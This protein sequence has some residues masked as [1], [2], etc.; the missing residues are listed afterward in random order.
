M[1]LRNLNRDKNMSKA[2]VRGKSPKN[3][4]T[5][6]V[7]IVGAGFAGMYM[8]HKIQQRGLSVRLYEAG[9]G[10]GGTWYWNRYPGARVD[11]ESVEYSYSFDD[12]LQQDWS[13]S[14][15]YA[16]QPELMR[17]ANY[18]ADRFSLRENMRCDTKV[19]AAVYDAEKLNWHIT[20]SQGDEVSAKYCVLATG[21]LSSGSVPDF[22]GLNDYNGNT[23]LTSKWPKEDINFK[24]Q[25]VAVIGT[26]SSA[27]QSIPIIAMQADHLT[28]F[29][30]TPSFSIPA[31]NGPMDREYE[32]RVKS[33]YPEW[34]RRQR[35]ESRAGFIA[36]NFQ[37]TAPNNKSAID[38]SDEERLIDYE[39]RW[40]SG[41]L[42][43]YNSFVDLLTNEKANDTL[44]KFVRNKIREK[45]KD[46]DTAELLAPKDY[47]IM[48]KR[49]CADTNYYETYNRENVS[50]VSIKDS[51][52]EKLT[53]KGVVVGG[54]EYEVDSVIFATGF[55]AVTG[56]IKNIDV[57]GV[58]GESL[59]E[60]WEG[61][62]RAYLGLM[63]NGFPNLFFL[64]GPCANGA[65]VSPML[66]SEHQ[67]E[68]VDRCI[69]EI[70]VGLAA[71][72]EPTLEA[73]DA[74]MQHMHDVGKDSLL[75][76][77]NSW[78]MGAN[79][80]GK[81]RALLSYL[82]GLESYRQQCRSGEANDYGNFVKT[83]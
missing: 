25:K 8:Q 19:T 82:G 21:F 28:V 23:Y 13:W 35:Y 11:V 42:C 3:Q 81:P 26:G 14:E 5:F 37:P 29:Q 54:H 51:P 2:G 64:D 69:N 61:A 80:P 15:R 41:G 77:A 17:Y 38:V 71:E 44:A 62:P 24:D 7:V 55:D 4:E 74:W 75:H 27:V 83:R 50:L 12:D 34:R 79:I 46:P 1:L 16:S 32:K 22:K 73:E 40:E 53:K 68:W 70:G 59:D 39:T 43:Y 36:L 65:L 63:S 9:S 33:D 72:I 20:T 58:A 67:V 57:R 49:L 45:V 66:L 6:D 18:F 47:P 10:V 52:I 48:A 30:R 60:H 56:A 76:L 31:R 78:Y